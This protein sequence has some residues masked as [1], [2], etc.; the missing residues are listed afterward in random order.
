MYITETEPGADLK[1]ASPAQACQHAAVGYIAH[2]NAKRTHGLHCQQH[3][4]HLA[5]RSAC[6][7]Q[8]IAKERP[9][10]APLLR[11]PL[12]SP[13]IKTPNA[14]SNLSSLEELQARLHFLH[15]LQ[16]LTLQF[17]NVMSLQHIK[18]DCCR[19]CW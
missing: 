6:P 1:P 16:E 5:Q 3:E 12:H 9:L 13:L 15:W 14:S 18:P 8:R 7:Q 4:L 2:R 17:P 19:Y 11:R 10:P